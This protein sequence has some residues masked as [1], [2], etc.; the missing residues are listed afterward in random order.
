[1]IKTTQIQSWLFLIFILG[2]HTAC[3]QDPNLTPTN[4]HI[5]FVQQYGSSSKQIAADVKQ[6]PDGGYIM[7]GSAYSQA[8]EVEA[9]ILV[10][11]T[12]AAGIEQWSVLLG[13]A[14]GMGTGAL[15]NE[16]VRYDE[17]AVKVE[18]LPNNGGYVIAGNRTYVAYPN[19][20]STVG[21]KHQ[22]KIVLY[23]LDL[24]GGLSVVNGTELKEG[25]EST[26]MLSDFKLD[27]NNGVI[28]YVLT[29][30]T[31]DI[32]TNKPIDPD[33][34]IYDLT[35]IFTTVLDDSFTPLWF[36]G[37][38]TYGFSGK[39]YGTSIQ[40][41]PDAYLVIGTVQE[42]DGNNGFNSK[43]AA[44][45]MRKDNGMPLSPKYFG[46]QDYD[47]A[48]GHSTYNPSTQKITIT[49]HAKN[50]S[51]VNANQVFVLQVDE[52][53]NTQY[54]NGTNSSTYG[55]KFLG[56]TAPSSL[57]LGSTYE[58]AS[59]DWLPNNEGFVIAVTH[60]D[61][62][63]TDIGIVNLE[64]NFDLRS[65]WPYYQGTIGNRSN[66]LAATVIAATNSAN[67]QAV[68]TFTGTFE[69][70]TNTSQIGLVQLNTTTAL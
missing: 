30:Y 53:L 49:G 16:Y 12:D 5:D 33:N 34:G 67:N 55:F 27:E 52:A 29:G 43:L 66:E 36:A 1:M 58:A 9:D 18:L 68:I 37:N 8:T 14:A 24:N 7:V 21:T 19:A 35:D 20:A 50:S 3:Q 51:L 31:T 11:K 60:E 4:A 38:S 47:L 48:G 22:S 41:L 15:S 64:A 65:G 2:F 32:T 62:L 61:Q 39:D 42:K 59:I 25:K 44:I 56:L 63:G 6:T 28:K 10:I 13:K 46:D 45:K 17:L 69:A 26:E 40:I 57:S 70:N 23:E 54:P